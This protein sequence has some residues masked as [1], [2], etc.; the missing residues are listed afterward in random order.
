MRTQRV[1]R[2][3][4][5]LSLSLVLH[6]GGWLAPHLRPLYRRKRNPVPHCIGGW[7]RPDVGLDGCRKIYLRQNSIPGPFS[8]YLV[9]IPITLFRPTTILICFYIHYYCFDLFLGQWVVS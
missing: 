3:S 9:A 6:E 2:D 8:L 4:C 1:S 7:V 5:T